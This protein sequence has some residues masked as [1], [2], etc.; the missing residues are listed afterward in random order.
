MTKQKFYQY[1]KNIDISKYCMD[2]ICPLPFVHAFY[3]VRGRYAPCCNA[4][5]VGNYSVENTRWNTWF[6]GA[7]MTQLRSD[8]ITGQKNNLCKRCWI[9]EE[10][11][12]DS[13]RLGALRE[14]HN[15]KRN[16]NITKNFYENPQ[17]I[18][19]DLKTSNF[20]N[21]ACVMCNGNSSTKISNLVS[22]LQDKNIPSAW[23]V[24]KSFQKTVDETLS[25]YIQKNITTL[26]VLKFT[27]GEPFLNK[28]F[29]KILSL[30]AKYNPDIY[31]VITTNGT[32]IH[33][34]F[35]P[36][37]KKLNNTQIKYSIDGI[38]NIYDY[39]RWPSKWLTFENT[40]LS[41]IDNL[42][43]IKFNISCLV[44]NLN[45]E[46]LPNLRSW[47][48]YY[49]KKYNNLEFIYFDTSLKPSNSPWSVN[50]L[51]LA[52]RNKLLHTFVNDDLQLN[53]ND[54]T[55]DISFSNIIKYIENILTASNNNKNCK[56]IV[57]DEIYKQDL[58]RG[59]TYKNCSMPI[60][61]EYLYDE[62]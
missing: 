40:I 57:L 5:V 30:A 51:P 23:R 61:K 39:I 52:V 3:N 50:L 7:V 13:P 35:L 17:P 33:K 6:Y 21:L 56:N 34:D 12:L 26:K 20:C 59:F 42:P 46:C 62:V 1:L 16:L 22:D 2:T 44:M 32:V 31:I 29:I 4:D 10:K 38:S 45:I 43:N 18:F 58:I 8:L 19:F 49:K 36:I 60:L 55:C 14:Y 27:G 15:N 47:F 24:N 28:D 37:L 41:S 11:N 54:Y 9:Q 25:T 53:A 48:H